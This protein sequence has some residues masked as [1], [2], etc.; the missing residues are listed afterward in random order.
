MFLSYLLLRV[1]LGWWG[2][3]KGWGKNPQNSKD[4]LNPPSPC[5]GIVKE[6]LLQFN[7]SSYLLTE[8]GEAFA[9]FS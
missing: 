1:K 8:A 7:Q 6:Y 4:Q 5:H 9:Y 3:I 2:G